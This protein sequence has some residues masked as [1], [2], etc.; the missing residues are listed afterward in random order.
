MS[1]KTK[2]GAFALRAPA[3]NDP[4]PA[5]ANDDAPAR[6]PVTF[7]LGTETTD[8]KP[9]QHAESFAAFRARALGYNEPHKGLAF[10]CAAFA[11]GAHSDPAVWKGKRHWRQKHL[12]QPRRWIPFDLDGTASRHTLDV[13]LATLQRFSGFAYLT[14]SS[15]PDALRARV[16]L[17]L[18]RE[19]DRTE[20]QRLGVA[21][22]ASFMREQDPAASF[23]VPKGHSSFHVWSVA[24]DDA[25]TFDGAVYRAEQPCYLPTQGVERWRFDG[26]PVDV[27]HVLSVAAILQAADEPE[28]PAI[29][30]PDDGALPDD[31]GGALSHVDPDDRDVWLRVGMALHSTG[32]EEAWNAWCNWSQR[33][34]KF[35]ADDQRKTWASFRDKSE[36]VT[37]GTVYRLARE[38]GWIR[39]PRPTPKSARPPSPAYKLLTGADVQALPPLE[40][41]VKGVL[42]ARGLA[43]VYGP[44]SSGKSFLALDMAAAIA[45]GHD[46][47]GYRVKQ[48]PVVYVMLEGAAG[49][50]QRTQAWCRTQGEPLPDAMRIVTQ[51]LRIKD[52]GDVDALAQTITDAG[53]QGAVVIVDTQNMA[54]PDADENSSADVG[55]ILQGA[56]KLGGLVGGVVVLVAHSGKDEGRG[57]RGHSSQRAAMDATIK[58]SRDGQAREWS[59]DKAK[60]G[61]DGGRH[62]FRLE[63]VK[64]G[65]DADGD[66]V[67]SCVVVR[68][69]SAKPR[70]KPSAGERAALKAYV[71]AC[72]R[73]LCR[74]DGVFAGLHLED[75]RSVF[76]ELSTGDNNEAKRQAF[77]RARRDMCAHG[78][79]TVDH[80]VYLAA[81]VGVT[82]RGQEFLNRRS[83]CHKRQ[84][85]NRDSVT[86]P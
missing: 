3:A 63:V 55:L 47:F 57:V 27:D 36:G 16:V 71:V 50:K 30:E 68:D 2:N 64:L 67:T 86:D 4:L 24:G 41:R 26:R 8:N 82:S 10:V 60:D 70:R 62:G 53:L 59:V 43:Q 33:S 77:H 34:A 45:G 61:T 81:D 80:D 29:E 52:A 12:A 15:T 51:P 31:I 69:D 13:L 58:V 1:L 23:T 18:S 20:G 73:G 6:Q 56:K 39:P 72:E 66:D 28:E 32:T 14:S 19:V 49:A 11:K 76:Y 40:W 22:E 78:F 46:W 54:A 42:P 65:E 48:A 5:A 9:K 38:S 17:E 83:Q 85:S 21:L 74:G 25:Y 79:M 84:T 44:P 7:S 37:L 35:D 75:W